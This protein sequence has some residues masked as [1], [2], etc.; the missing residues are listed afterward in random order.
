MGLVAASALE[1][2][3]ES[4]S[5][6]RTSFRAAGLFRRALAMLV[7]AGLLLPLQSFFWF[8]LGFS[9]FSARPR[10][11]ELS[12]D[13]LVAN[14][15]DGSLNTSTVALFGLTGAALYFATFLTLRGQTPGKWLLRIRVVDVYGDRPSLL[16]SLGRVCGYAL[17]VLP[18]SLGVLWI[19]FDREKRGLHDFLAGTY[20]VHM[21]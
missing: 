18:F 4:A 11:S 8:A 9:K 14:L 20:V 21:P 10:F 19:G 15:S 2:R 17:A 13:V 3:V 12:P 6:P 5:T 16:R 1:P 7:D